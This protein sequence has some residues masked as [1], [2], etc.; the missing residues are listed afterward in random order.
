MRERSSTASVWR[1]YRDG[2]QDPLG[3]LGLSVNV[4]VLWNTLYMDAALARLRHQGIK[5]KPDDLACVSP[6]GHENI[7]FLRR[8]SFALP[9]SVARGELRSLHDLGNSGSQALPNVA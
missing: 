5:P 9:E 8:Y 2:Q 4:V 1:G 7:N 6:F 3:A